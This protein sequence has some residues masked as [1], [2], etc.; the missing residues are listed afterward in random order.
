MSLTRKFAAAGCLTACLALAAPAVASAQPST[1]A[2]APSGGPGPI[3]ITLSAEQ[4]QM[5]C[6]ERLPKIEARTKKLTERINGDENTKGST[7][8]LQAKAAKAKAGGHEDIAKR[9]TDRAAKRP[10]Q[11]AKVTK[12]SQWATEFA[13]KY[14]K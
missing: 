13:G 2:P 10:A 14:C 7:K 3:T 6:G 11:L 8:W 1:T 4:A 12:I 5:L 9:L